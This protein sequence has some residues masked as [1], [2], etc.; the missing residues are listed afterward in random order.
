VWLV[1]T[2]VWIGFLRG[3]DV[4]AVGRLRRRLTR[5]EPVALTPVIYQERLQGAD[6]EARFVRFQEHFGSQRFVVPAD[7]V[8]AAAEA[9]LIYFRCRRAG[10]TVRSTIDCAIVQV[11]LEHQLLL[12]HNDRDFVQIGGVIPELTLI[13]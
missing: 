10:I 11:A 2:S 5:G 8:G 6:S 7:P 12:L 3:D 13:G 9:A 1:D 4:P